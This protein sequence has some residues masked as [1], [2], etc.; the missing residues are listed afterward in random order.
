MKEYKM[1]I[2]SV[3]Q[4]LFGGSS[5]LIIHAYDDMEAEAKA[6]EIISIMCNKIPDKSTY[7]IYE[8]IFI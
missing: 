4:H 7:Q 8:W 1:R 6:D 5:T 2:K 3:K